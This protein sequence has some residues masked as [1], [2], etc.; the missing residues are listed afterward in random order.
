MTLQLLRTW[1]RKNILVLDINAQ[2]WQKT[3][4]FCSNENDEKKIILEI[5]T[6]SLTVLLY[7]LV[8]YYIFIYVRFTIHARL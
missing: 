8:F 3:P 5:T 1:F 2:R 4:M 7:F 6:L